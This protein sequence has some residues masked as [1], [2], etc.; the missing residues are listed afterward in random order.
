MVLYACLPDGRDPTAAMA[1]LRH[2]AEARD[3][4]V[5]AALYDTAPI[6]T[7]CTDREAWPKVERLVEG[8]EVRGVVAGSED[9]I[10]CHPPAKA[11]LRTWLIANRAFAAYFPASA[12][13]NPTLT[14]LQ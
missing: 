8:W 2:H 1:F 9:E 3:W 10:A 5:R 14:H 11:Q 6:T 4:V 7:T 13:Q 12:G